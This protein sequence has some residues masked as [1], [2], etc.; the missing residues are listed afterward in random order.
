MS[1]WCDQ[2]EFY[3]ET[4]P[5]AK[6]EHRCCECSGVIRVGEVYARSS[7]KYDG[8]ISTDCQHKDCRDFAAKVNLKFIGGCAI[9]FGDVREAMTSLRHFEEFALVS[10]DYE[11]GQLTDA[12]FAALKEEWT[13]IV[14]RHLSTEQ[15]TDAIEGATK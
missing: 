13:D 15:P 9:P 5:R 12:D 6:K 14:T 8:V 11:D 3:N 7:A 4:Y 1:E 10:E 2:P